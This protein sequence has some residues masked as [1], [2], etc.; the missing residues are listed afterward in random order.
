MRTKV[1]VTTRKEGWH[2]WCEAPTRRNYLTERHRHLFHIRVEINVAGPR[3]AEFH[4]LLD[5]VHGS[6]RAMQDLW[7]Q[8]EDASCEEMAV[9]L[10]D[11]LCD[12][13]TVSAIEVWEDGECG[14][15]VEFD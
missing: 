7:P 2:R 6:W 3:K 13:F 14:A 1:I 9:K 4:D 11:N 5:Y 15:R 12:R 10:K 8:M